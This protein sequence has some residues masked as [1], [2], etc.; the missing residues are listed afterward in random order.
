MRADGSVEKQ[1]FD[2]FQRQHMQRMLYRQGHASNAQMK[3]D[4]LV[5]GGSE[6][7]DFV[8][9]CIDDTMF[10]SD[11]M[12]PCKTIQRAVCGFDLLHVG[13]GPT[14]DLIRDDGSFIFSK[15]RKLA[16]SMFGGSTLVGDPDRDPRYLIGI[17]LE[18]TDP[19]QTV[20][21][22]EQVDRKLIQETILDN[23]NYKQQVRDFI[24]GQTSEEFAEAH[25]Q[26]LKLTAACTGHS[27]RL[28]NTLHAGPEADAPVTTFVS[29]KYESGV[30]LT[31]RTDIG[32]NFWARE[33]VGPSTWPETS[34][35][36]TVHKSME[37]VS[38]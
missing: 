15:P 37:F 33:H 11:A 26:C 22:G 1:D 29:D 2:E 32:W 25:Q 34:V 9:T 3:R 35:P 23:K 14:V 19:V 24:N 10:S 6:M 16:P 30:R 20:N 7:K 5:R 31:F 4:A 13:I 8:A 36:I 17:M 21:G 38:S 18:T 12:F 27:I 28:I